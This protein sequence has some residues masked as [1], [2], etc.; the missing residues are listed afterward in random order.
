MTRLQTAIYDAFMY[1]LAYVL[2]VVCN[3]THGTINLARLTCRIKC[4]RPEAMCVRDDVEPSSSHSMY[5]LLL[6]QKN[7]K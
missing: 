5:L 2:I 6:W 4:L 7:E 3:S 1:D